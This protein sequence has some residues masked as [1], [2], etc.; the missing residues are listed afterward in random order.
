MANQA[1]LNVLARQIL[2]EP[3][4]PGGAWWWRTPGYKTTIENW[5]N[6]A[7]ENEMHAAAAAHSEA[8]EQKK[9]KETIDFIVTQVKPGT[10]VLD[11]GCG[12]G[13]IAKYLLPQVAFEAYVGVDSSLVML[14][15]FHERYVTLPTEQR[16]PLLLAHGDIDHL[17]VR[18]HSIDLCIVSAVFLH[19]HKDVTQRAIAEIRRVLKPGGKL[20]IMA[21]F[22]NA[23]SLTGLQGA[24]FLLWLKLRGRAR[25]NGPVRYF[26]SG[27]IKRMLKGFKNV[28]LYPYGFSLYP[29]TILGLPERIWRKHRRLHDTVHGFLKQH[30]PKPVQDVFCTYFDVVAEA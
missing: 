21:S 18:D 6:L 25:K 16:T 26:T 19:N 20:L 14:Q 8:S 2:A 12:Y 22:P 1:E 9:T 13:R 5:N 15:K 27:E 11:V 28:S 24:L 4:E 3:I 23:R 29:K 10:R 7:T 17:P 30:L